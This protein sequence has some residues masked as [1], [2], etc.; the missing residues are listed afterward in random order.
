MATKTHR[1]LLPNCLRDLKGR[2]SY[3]TGDQ[4][5]LRFEPGFPVGISG[6]CSVYTGR[7]SLIPRVAVT[8]GCGLSSCGSRFNFRTLTAP[9]APTTSLNSASAA[10]V[11]D[12]TSMAFDVTPCNGAEVDKRLVPGGSCGVVAV[13]WRAREE[14]TSSMPRT[15]AP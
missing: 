7:R 4:A 15:A 2:P 12:V 3:G 13:G 1:E 10:I 9:T 5:E 14:T 8:G 6:S 11:L